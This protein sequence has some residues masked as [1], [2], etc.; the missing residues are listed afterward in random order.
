M[1]YL[2]EVI[3]RTLRMYSYQ[4]TDNCLDTLI[5]EI[6]HYHAIKRLMNEVH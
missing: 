4:I 5:S 3:K 6:E 2:P 1:I